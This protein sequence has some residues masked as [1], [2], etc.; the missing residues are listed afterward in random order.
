MFHV[1]TS[2][3][4]NVILTFLGDRE[5]IPDPEFYAACIEQSFADLMK[6]TPSVKGKPKKRQRKNQLPK[7]KRSKRKTAKKPK[8]RVAASAATAGRARKKA[9]K[10]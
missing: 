4:G 7:R 3:H 9:A 2:Y 5:I 8:K 6:A 1:V 10:K